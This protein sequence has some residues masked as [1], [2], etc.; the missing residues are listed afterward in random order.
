[1]NETSVRCQNGLLSAELI[2]F[3]TYS[4]LITIY[5]ADGNDYM[6]AIGLYTGR[7]LRLHG[8]GGTNTYLIDGSQST[9][10]DL[11]RFQLASSVTVYGTSYDTVIV[12]TS[13]MILL[14]H[15]SACI[16]LHCFVYAM[17]W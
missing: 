11:S 3:T 7:S 9:N 6:T 16:V 17:L 13:M 5:G 4:G 1:V 12:D 14:C 2:V 10:H 8:N 15:C